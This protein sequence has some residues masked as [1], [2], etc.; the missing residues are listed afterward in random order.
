MHLVVITSVVS[1][2]P[3]LAPNVF[4]SQ[5]R[6]DQLLVSIQSV[7]RKIP[8]PIIVV[9]EGSPYTHEQ[10]LAV[11]S[12]GAN[13]IFY[14]DTYDKKVGEAWSLHEFF[15][16]SSFQQL[17]RQYVF[18]SINK[19][20]GRYFLLNNFAFFYDGELCVCKVDTPQTSYSGHGFIYTRY[21][22]V[23]IQ[24]L[25]HYT[26][27]LAKCCQDLFINLEHSFY[28]HNVIPLNKINDRITKINVGGLIAP[29]GEYVED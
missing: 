1:P 21:Y 22:S 16:S 13:Y 19:L 17:H 8:D 10:T 4:S 18:K 2:V 5:E 20:S 9:L 29:T 26:N 3:E 11:K 15:T 7:V 24:Y 6:F 27:G 12:V 28:L 23:P 14:T 25:H